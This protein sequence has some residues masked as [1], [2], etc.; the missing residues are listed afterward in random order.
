MKQY[1]VIIVGAGPAG[2]SAAVY[3]ARAELDTL[4][5]DAKDPGGQILN[6]NEVQNYI[7]IGAVSGSALG[8]R[9]FEHTQQLN[10]P[11]ARREVVRIEP[12]EPMHRIWVKGEEAPYETRSI[13]LAV[14][15]TPKVL[16]VENE[17]KFYRNGISWCV[18]C[19]GA[20]YVGKDVVV[21]GGGNS[22]VKESLFMAN[23]ASSLTMLTKYDLTA[24]EA[25]IR[26]L[27]KKPN[28]TIMTYQDILGFV[29]DDRLSGVRSLDVKS[30]KEQI[31]PCAGVF[32]YIGLD[33]HTAFLKD[34]GILEEHGYVVVNA[35]METAIP[36]IYGAGDCN[37]KDLRQVVTACSDGAIAAQNAAHYLRKKGIS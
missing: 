24:D 32:E 36:G 37:V 13:I 3:A 17:E 31:I 8:Y 15:T 30:G 14:G 1:D 29:G 33:Q 23:I 27:K 20:Q 18:I 10:V 22:G 16:H 7:G 5:L 25:A 28:V 35:S 6:T 2:M 34:L 26:Q 4:M 12:G 9:M 21:I 19:D 11:F